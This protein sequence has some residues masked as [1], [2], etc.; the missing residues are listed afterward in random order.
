MRG[1]WSAYNLNQSVVEK[2]PSCFKSAF[3]A[4]VVRFV[5]SVILYICSCIVV[6]EM[7]GMWPNRPSEK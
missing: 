3:A 5:V 7:A 2:L 1:T 4:I 6:V